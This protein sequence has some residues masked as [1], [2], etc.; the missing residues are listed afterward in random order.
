MASL[1]IQHLPDELYEWLST[2]AQRHQRSLERE[3][4]F[5]LEAARRRQQEVEQFI[6][7]ARRVRATMRVLL[8]PQEIETAIN[9]GRE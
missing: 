5:S 8:T 7:D 4:L 1:T 6:A 9:E 2:S 3:A